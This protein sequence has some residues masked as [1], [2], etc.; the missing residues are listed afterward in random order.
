[1]AWKKPIWDGDVLK[2]L[3]EKR[4]WTQPD[5]LDH[6]LRIL[7]GGVSQPT[8]SNWERGTEPRGY[9]QIDAC[10]HVLEVTPDQFFRR[11][12]VRKP[13]RTPS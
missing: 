13:S 7:R 8:Y 10:A 5:M 6:L 9:A 11:E 1:M 2:A 4:G 3:R 12:R